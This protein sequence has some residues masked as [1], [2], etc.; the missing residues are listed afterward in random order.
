V[1]VLSSRMTAAAYTLRFSG[2]DNANHT[3]EIAGS[4][5]F[6]P[7]GAIAAGVEDVVINGAYHQYTTVS[8]S[9][10]PSTV[11]DNNSNNA[12]TLAL[13][14]SGGPTYTFT[15]VLD[16]AGNL[17][18]I[19][20][21][22]NGTG[23]GSM[24]KTAVGQFNT[25]AQKF[26]FEFTGADS[27][28]ERVGYVGLLPMTPNGATSGTIG[29]GLIDVNDNGTT[30]GVCGQSPCDVGGTSSYQADA[31]IGGLWHMT[32]ATGVL[33]HF[34]FFIG[35]GQTTTNT[36]SPLALYAISTDPIDSTHPALA[37]RMLFQDPGTTYDKTALNSDSVSHLTGVDS[38][39][40]N[41]LVS[42]VAVT[43]DGN[44]NLS[45]TFDSNNA[46]TIVAAATQ[47][48]SCTYTTD[49]NQTGRYVVT[50]LGTG[51]SCTG[52]LPFVFYASGANRGLLLDQSSPEVR[53]GAMDPQAAPN[54]GFAPSE[55]PNTYAA[56]TASNATSGVIPIA[57]NLLLTSPGSQTYNVSGTQYTF[58]S[59]LQAVAVTGTYTLMLTGTG[60][61]ALT[62]PSANYVIYA[63]D[64]THFEMIDVDKT[65]TN[66][67]VIFAQQ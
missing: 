53:T 11:A 25:A 56:G 17:R 54:G 65:V 5:T 51:S 32:L 7:D 41:T 35:S 12:G 37:G 52:G 61:I 33:Q 46:G 9:Y 60:T 57:A 47:A 14:A 8:G 36:K 1:T 10:T 40:A 66:P 44:G 26:V 59:G 34:D 50:L 30:I 43:G 29:G 49:T 23:S 67:S 20:S 45:E 38:T 55:L 3:V 58:T 2:H 39:G 18:M 48:A 6:G 42:L 27:N 22:G 16:A 19:E 13:S 31:N 15:A 21:D 64:P 62:T 4:V 24:E 63:T 28:R